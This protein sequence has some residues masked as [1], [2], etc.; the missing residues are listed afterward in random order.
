LPFAHERT[1]QS[2]PWIDPGPPATLVTGHGS[3][4]PQ[5]AASDLEYK[6]GALYV[7]EA[8]ARLNDQTILDMSPNSLG[9]ST[10][11]TDDGHGYT[12]NPYTG[13]PYADNFVKFGDYARVM[14]E[15]WADGPTSE[16]PP[17]HW[18]VLANEV[19]DNSLTVKR[20]GGTGPIVDDLEWDVK[21]YFALAG[22]THDAACAVWGVKR[23][24]QG[25]RP[26]TAIRY[27]GAL[28][29]SSNPGGPSYHPQGLLLED[30]VCE[31]VTAQSSAT[32]QRHE[33]IWDLNSNGYLPGNALIGEV[34]VYSWPGEPAS[35]S[36]QTSSVRWMR[37]RDWV[38]YQRKTFNTPAFPGY[39]SGHS[40]FS[41]AAAEV[42]TAVTN[43]PFFPGGIGTFTA[44]ANA[45]LVFEQ[46]PTQ[47][48]QLQ[49]ATYYDA[50]D[51]AGQSRRWGGIHVRE[52]D[53]KSRIIG[54]QSGKQVWTLAKKY[55]DGSI[56]NESVVPTQTIAANGSVTITS[57]ARRGLYYQWEYTTDLTTWIPIGSSTRAT[58]TTL[59]LND[60]PPPGQR[61]FYRAR[62]IASGQ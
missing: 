60:T 3:P 35:P 32:G 5:Q 17:G 48:T 58:G 7:L 36:T 31:V 38:P 42:M 34:V 49:W 40:G 44:N 29:Q 30:G 26:I 53:Y 22:A 14:A 4:T 20:I 39:I 33:Q 18:H 61:R 10:L 41:R 47:T 23:Y 9:N 51:L 21:T 25:V 8:S 46:G 28:G 2:L 55:F 11:G 62:W 27:M 1:N 56:L 13:Q 16:T 52:D 50:A 54:A 6:Q 24:Y 15:F 45:Y 43:N 57:H 19:A 12:V 59:M 37:A